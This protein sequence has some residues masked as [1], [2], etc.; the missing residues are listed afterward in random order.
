MLGFFVKPAHFMTVLAIALIVAVAALIV[1]INTGVFE[2]NNR[3]ALKQERDAA[4]RV[5]PN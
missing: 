4:A 5:Q 2:H 3:A 1:G